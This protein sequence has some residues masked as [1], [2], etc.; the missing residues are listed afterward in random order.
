MPEDIDVTWLTAV[1]TKAGGLEKGEVTRVDYEKLESNW[2]SNAF[3][4][5]SYS[6]DAL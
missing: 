3:L 1:L 4:T 5:L 2:S 6:K